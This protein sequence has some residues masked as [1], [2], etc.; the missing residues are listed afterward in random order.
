METPKKLW[1][2]NPI[3]NIV[4]PDRLFGANCGTKC[5]CTTNP[6]YAVNPEH[7]LTMRE[8]KEIKNNLMKG[9][10]HGV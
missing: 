3:K 2:C 10:R 4:C 5:F 6:E 1:V 9:T 7:P 8:Y